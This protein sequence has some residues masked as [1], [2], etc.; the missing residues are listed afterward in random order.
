MSL[1]TDLVNA[2]YDHE[3]TKESI[4]IERKRFVH[5]NIN[6]KISNIEDAKEILDQIERDGRIMSAH[7]QRRIHHFIL[8]HRPKNDIDEMGDILRIQDKFA[9]LATHPITFG[10]WM[11][12]KKRKV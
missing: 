1:K 5:L 9:E 3:N 11:S 6:S 12:E 2:I 7:D 4:D 10:C 8:C